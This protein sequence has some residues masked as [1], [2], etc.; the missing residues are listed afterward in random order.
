MLSLIDHYKKER[1]SI[2]A[3]E[4]PMGHFI[5]NI[6]KSHAKRNVNK[7]PCFILQSL[8]SDEKN[9]EYLAISFLD[10]SL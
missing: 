1:G 9:N 6:K 10:K 4:E 8:Q 2:T 3:V 5:D 7:K